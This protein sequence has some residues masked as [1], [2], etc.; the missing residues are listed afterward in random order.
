MVI[1]VNIT[2]VD[3]LICVCVIMED[4]HVYVQMV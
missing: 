2:M 1:F 3:V 4:E